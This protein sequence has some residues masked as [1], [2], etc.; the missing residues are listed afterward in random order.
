MVRLEQYSDENVVF[1]AYPRYK[2]TIWFKNVFDTFIWPDCRIAP[3]LGS[4]LACRG[5]AETTESLNRNISFKLGGALE[6]FQVNFQLEKEELNTTIRVR[7]L[8]KTNRTL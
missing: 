2:R 5:E 3:I 7:K 6:D 1:S 8:F 4:F